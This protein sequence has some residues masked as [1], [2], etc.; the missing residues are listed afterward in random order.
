MFKTLITISSQGI[1][2]PKSCPQISCLEHI[3]ALLQ[4]PIIVHYG[5]AGPRERISSCIRSSAMATI[6][7]T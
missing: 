3:K 7:L 2:L 5:R 6:T 1:N 4:P